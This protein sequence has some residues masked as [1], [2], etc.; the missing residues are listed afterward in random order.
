MSA[1]RS[2][3]RGEHTATLA[4]VLED[5]QG[6]CTLVASMLLLDLPDDVRGELAACDEQLTSL[7]VTLRRHLRG[8][9]EIESGRHAA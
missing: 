7:I 9:P 3:G 1:N 8:A 6:C 2:N 5:A 4:Q